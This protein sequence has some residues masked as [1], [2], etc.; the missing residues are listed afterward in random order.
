MWQ[1]VASVKALLGRTLS[2]ASSGCV[3]KWLRDADMLMSNVISADDD[4][5]EV[6]DRSMDAC[7]AVLST[8]Q[9]STNCTTTSAYVT[10]LMPIRDSARLYDP[11]VSFCVA[12]Q[13]QKHSQST[14][15]PKVPSVGLPAKRA[16]ML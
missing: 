1:H 8:T 13:Q 15:L 9:I 5:V 4:D 2:V 14:R 7:R 10:D 6:V 11:S 12:Q 16:A 3:S